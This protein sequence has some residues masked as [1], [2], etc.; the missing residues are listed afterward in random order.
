[1][2]WH[3]LITWKDVFSYR[4]KVFLLVAGGVIVGL[5]L[6]FLYLLR[7]HT[8]IAG[9][10][11]AA[12]VNCHIMTPY[13]ATWSRSSHSRDATCNDCHV[14]NGN[15]ATHYGFKGLDGMKHVAY[16]VT[17]S[18]RQA[19]RAET[20]SAQVIM[21]NCI[22]CHKQLNTEFVKTGRIDYMQAKRDEGMA[23]WD[24]HRNVPHGGMNALTS[25]PNAETQVPIPPSPV[26]RWLQKVL[27]NR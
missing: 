19:I 18:E 17:H 12:C 5:T 4:Q 24:C 11:P 7:M 8:Y 20:A 1:M 9:D 26:P 6:L 15:I 16:F 3:K 22:R 25:T 23:C 2:N 10:D 27:G 13:Y 14:P 21:D